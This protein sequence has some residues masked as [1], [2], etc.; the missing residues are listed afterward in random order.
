METVRSNWQ[1][2]GGYCPEK[3]RKGTGGMIERKDVMPLNY[4][5]KLGFSGSHK[6]MRYLL[7]KSTETVVQDVENGE[8]EEKS[9]DK[10]EAVIWPQPFNFEVT[11]DDEKESEQFP[12][13]D[14]GILMAI[15]WMNEQY[16]NQR[17]R[18]EHTLPILDARRVAPEWEK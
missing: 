7:R 5:K 18:W 2:S 9:V 1:V 8:K 15:E 12:F 17:D 11:P 14:E 4:Y 6:G 3:A 13:T 10:L 16:Q